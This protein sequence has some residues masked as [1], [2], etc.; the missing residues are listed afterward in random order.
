VNSYLSLRGF[1]IEELG[2][3]FK[4]TP[5]FIIFLECLTGKPFELKY[6]AKPKLIHHHLENAQQ[7][8]N[9]LKSIKV[10]D[11][12]ISPEE[13]VDGNIK[14]MLGFCWVML[15]YFGKQQ[16]QRSGGGNDNTSFEDSILNW[17]REEVKGYGVDVSSFKTSF[18]DGKV[19]LALCHKINPN[20]IDYHHTD[21]SDHHSNGEN[22]LHLIEKQYSIPPLLNVD[23]LTMGKESEKNIVLYLSLVHGAWSREQEKKKVTDV[24]QEKV[25]TLQE[26]L[27]ILEE[28]NV[29]LKE[30]NSELQEKVEQ[31]RKLLEK[32]TE[33]K[34][35]L[36]ENKEEESAK[37]SSEK[38]ILKKMKDKLD[39]EKEELAA[40]H[41]SLLQKLQKQQRAK[42]QLEE[43]VKKHQNKSGIGMEYIRKNLTEHLQDLAYW[44][45]FLEK[46]Y[47]FKKETV[48]LLTEDNLKNDSFNDQYL[49]MSKAVVE[50]NKRV[51][52]ILEEREKAKKKD[53][54]K[55]STPEA[56]QVIS[57]KDS[58]R[59]K[60]ASRKDNR[61]SNFKKKT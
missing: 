17:V 16:M 49:K 29:S 60:R 39:K 42:D 21:L 5:L 41:L 34:A 51:E 57:P 28:R 4:N 27:I 52:S 2:L 30:H 6:H 14:M 54:D 25:L 46:E 7:S 22:A 8:L 24:A 35:E 1:K 43:A 56:S 36:R 45:E 12:T 31:L 9:F 61:K 13:I 47:D 33:E 23:S 26:K 32:E 55:K 59:T 40:E 58:P 3:D 11:I 18:N 37:I 10:P 44:K 19:L 50:E 48:K 15:R 53:D 20:L 38:E